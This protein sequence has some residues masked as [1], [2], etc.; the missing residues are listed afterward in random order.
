M[1]MI[2]FMLDAANIPFSVA[3]AIVALIAL[4]EGVGLLLGMALSGLLDN[5]VPEIDI[6]IDTPD[7]ADHGAFGEF[8]VWLRFREVPVIVILIAFL[9]SF[10]IT[11]FIL[12]QISVFLFGVLLPALIA[13]A[14]AMFACLPGVRIFAGTLGKVMPKDE[15]E[16]V[17]Q[18]SFI[19]REAIITL[20]SASTHNPAQGRVKDKFGYSHYV[21]IEPD[22]EDQTFL[23]GEKVLVVRQAGSTFFAIKTP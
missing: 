20:G 17:G 3:L 1:K 7:M 22:N 16:A 5:L 4:I 19:G 15:T 11:G 14:L 18:A 2:E 13:S 8:L 9:T 10:S 23:Q 12:Q 6:N 21:M